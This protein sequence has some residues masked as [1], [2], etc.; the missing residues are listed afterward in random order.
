MWGS[1]I[2]KFLQN[3]RIFARSGK[4]VSKL[5]CSFGLAFSFSFSFSLSS[6]KSDESEVLIV[7]WISG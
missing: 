7:E 1:T 5:L 6:R 4:I 2:E 3:N